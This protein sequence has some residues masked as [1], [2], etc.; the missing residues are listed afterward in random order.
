MTEEAGTVL[1]ENSLDI[2]EGIWENGDFGYDANGNQIRDMSRDVEDIQYDSCNRPVKVTTADEEIDFLYSANGTKLAQIIPE[3]DIRRDY[4][5]A[6]EL[7]DG[8]LERVHVGNGFFT[9]ADSVLHVYLRDIQ[10]GVLAVYNTAGSRREQIVETYPYGMPHSSETLSEVDVNRRWFGG[11]EFTAESGVNLYDFNARWLNPALA[12]FTTPDPLAFDTP[13]VS[14]YTFCAGDP[15]NYS[16]PTGL[17]RDEKEGEKYAA[18]YWPGC[19]VLTDKATGE[20][21]ISVTLKDHIN[22]NGEFTVTVVRITKHIDPPPIDPE[23]AIKIAGG[24]GISLSVQNELIKF[25]APTAQ[26]GKTLGAF[27]NVSTKIAMKTINTYKGTWMY[28]NL[29]ATCVIFIFSYTFCAIMFC[30]VSGVGSIEIIGLL[31]ATTFIQLSLLFALFAWLCYKINIDKAILLKFS[32][33]M[34]ISLAY[35]I[36]FYAEISIGNNVDHHI[37]TIISKVTVL[38]KYVESAMMIIYA[39]VPYI[40]MLPFILLYSKVYRKSQRRVNRNKSLKP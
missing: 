15:V 32:H 23:N 28:L 21:F 6:F 25:A 20:A 39:I 29:I 34:Y 33:T 24:L 12:M 9:A 16:D 30:Y 1:L 19:P 7:C 13:D 27:Y 38:S 35:S 36:I 14:P 18:K 2:P 3:N 40:L 26:M 22:E 4:C 11:K 17:F 8:V 31:W 5:G 37:Y 10:G